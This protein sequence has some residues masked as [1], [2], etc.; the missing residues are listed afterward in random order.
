M[1][2]LLVLCVAVL[3]LAGCKSRSLSLCMSPRVTG[4]VLAADTG[5]PLAD[6]KVLSGGQAGAPKGTVPPKG[7]QLL[8]V[9]ASVRTDQDG[10]F[11]LESEKVLTPFGG[12]G[13][14]S[15]QLFFE[16][17]GYE[18]FYT[19]YSRLDLHTN[20]WKGEQVLSAGDILL[21]PALK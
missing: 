7:G 8:K 18:G 21:Q 20:S 12:I 14:F 1:N 4:R 10:R 2:R 11:A 15:V 9:K 17:V 5:Q 19:N 13:W 16:R 6:V 3:A